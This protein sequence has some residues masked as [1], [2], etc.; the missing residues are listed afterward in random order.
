MTKA[1][2]ASAKKNSL[3]APVNPSPTKNCLPANSSLTNPNASATRGLT[4][5]AVI[6]AE[7]APVRGR[8]R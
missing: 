4:K 1:S 5:L 2:K 8:A 3:S 7:T 6:P